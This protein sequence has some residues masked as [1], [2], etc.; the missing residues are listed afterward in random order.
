MKSNTNAILGG[1]LLGVAIILLLE[2]VRTAGQRGA[3]LL[4]DRTMPYTPK[5]GKRKADSAL[6]DPRVGPPP[7]EEWN[8]NQTDINAPYQWGKN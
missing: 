1:G 5:M 6:P 2:A 8:K 3:G 7:L 4:T